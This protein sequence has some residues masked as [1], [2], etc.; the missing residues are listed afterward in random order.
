MV[1]RK[2]DVGMEEVGL[3]VRMRCCREPGPSKSAYGLVEVK[4]ARVFGMSRTRAIF[5]AFLVLLFLIS[6]AS[7]WLQPSAT[8]VARA[9]AVTNGRKA[10]QLTMAGFHWRSGTFGISQSQE[11]DFFVGNERPPKKVRVK[12]S[13]PIYF[14]GWRVEECGEVRE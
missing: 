3:T 4:R 2:H 11:V 12:L 1:Y 9:A 13:R 10:N 5:V 7:S 14:L 8:E 6:L